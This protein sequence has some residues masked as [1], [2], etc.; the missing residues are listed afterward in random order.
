LS[1]QKTALQFSLRYQD[2][3]SGLRLDVQTSG[4]GSNPNNRL[5]K[6]LARR[7]SGGSILSRLRQ[8]LDADEVPR[9]F[10]KGAV[11]VRLHRPDGQI[12]GYLPDKSV[13]DSPV[14]IGNGLGNT[15]SLIF[16]FPWSTNSLEEAWIEVSLG[17]ERCWLEVPY[18]FND[19]P[20]NPLARSIVGGRPRLAPAM[21]K[22]GD[23][24]HL[25]H[26]WMVHYDLGQIPN[27][28]RLSLNQ[29]ATPYG[30]DSDVELYKEFGSRWSTN[31]PHVG[32]RLLNSGGS[33]AKGVAG[34]RGQRIHEDSMRRT[35]S[36]TALPPEETIREWGQIEISVDDKKYAVSVP[37]SLYEAGHGHEPTFAAEYRTKF[38]MREGRLFYWRLMPYQRRVIFEPCCCSYDIDLIKKTARE[39]VFKIAQAYG[40]PLDLISGSIT[41]KT[42]ALGKEYRA[43]LEREQI[44]AVAEVQPE[45]HK[46]AL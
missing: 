40:V 13:A 17:K 9:I 33:V 10:K 46:P 36:F 7:L 27:G 12:V 25:V 41:S 8:W 24:D 32:F 15:W 37:S 14:G 34:F 20:L 42:N 30:G 26:W 3:S 5:M 35:D 45:P 22:L 38:R 21:A 6:P 43:E 11:S 29:S 39:C 2:E 23:G 1:D 31:S 28:W 44:I 16:C 19:D 18:G 4:H